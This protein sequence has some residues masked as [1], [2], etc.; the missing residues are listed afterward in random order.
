MEE[1]GGLPSMGLHR[2]RHDWSDLAAAVA[3]AKSSLSLWNLYFIV[4]KLYLSHTSYN[5]YKDQFVK[6][7]K[8][9]DGLCKLQSTV[10]I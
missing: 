4:Y 6:R 3:A 2:V 5:Y 8:V 9:N 1:P 10:W 7:Q